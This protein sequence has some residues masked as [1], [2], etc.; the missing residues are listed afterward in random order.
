[1]TAWHRLRHLLVT[2]VPSHSPLS[3][4]EQSSPWSPDSRRNLKDDSSR[5]AVLTLRPCQQDRL[6]KRSLR[7]MRSCSVDRKDAQDVRQPARPCREQGIQTAGERSRARTE[8]VSRS[9]LR[10]WNLRRSMHCVWL[11]N[12]P[13]TPGSLL[14]RLA[15][16]TRG[17]S[18]VLTQRE[19]SHVAGQRP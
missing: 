12:G 4:C 10:R 13:H 7:C 19:F 5:A 15:V 14:S 1:M 8:A 17:F 18:D 11:Q 9:S 2:A 6:G 3:P 16:A